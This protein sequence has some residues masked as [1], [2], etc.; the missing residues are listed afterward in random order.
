[1]LKLDSGPVRACAQIL[2]QLRLLGF[3]L[4]PGVLKTTAGSQE[5]DQNCGPFKTQFRKILDIVVQDRQKE[6]ES[7][8]ASLQPWLV[9]LVI[10]GGVEPETKREVIV[11]DSFAYAFSMEHNLDAWSKI[12]AAPLTMA[13]LSDPKVRREV[14]DADDDTNL[15]MVALQQANDLAS[16]TLTMCGYNGII[17]KFE[18]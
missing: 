1:M 12:G 10:F 6:N 13:C 7:K 17:L 14:G 2:A 11:T 4:Y 18:E 9:G 3:Y 15:L 16:Q 8:A 5:M